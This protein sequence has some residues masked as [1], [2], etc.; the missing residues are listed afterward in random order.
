MDRQKR[1]RNEME[2]KHSRAQS[3]H[4]VRL[5]QKTEKHIDQLNRVTCVSAWNKASKTGGRVR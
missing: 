2:G 3:C 4:L 5:V 1:H